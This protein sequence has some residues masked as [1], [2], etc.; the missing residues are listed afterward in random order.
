MPPRWMAFCLG[1]PIHILKPGETVR[2]AVQVEEMVPQSGESDLLP[3]TL[4]AWL[5]GAPAADIY[6][7]FHVSVATA[8]LTDPYSDSGSPS[9]QIP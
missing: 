6:S 4:R 7:T 2:I 3:F 1:E 9:P 5:P 8:A